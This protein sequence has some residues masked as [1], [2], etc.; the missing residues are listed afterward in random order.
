MTFCVQMKKLSHF[1]MCCIHQRSLVTL[2]QYN[3]IPTIMLQFNSLLILFL[4]KKSQHIRFYSRDQPLIDY[5]VSVECLFHLQ[6]LIVSHCF[7]FDG[8]A[9]PFTFSH[10]VAFTF[11]KMN[12]V[13]HMRLTYPSIAILSKLCQQSILEPCKNVNNNPCNICPLPEAQKFTFHSSHVKASHAFAL[14]YM[15]L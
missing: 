7:S 14:L 12:D 3:Y 2:Y 15:D 9:V 6:F 4:L 13:W 11:V 8:N 1:L 10:L 5:I